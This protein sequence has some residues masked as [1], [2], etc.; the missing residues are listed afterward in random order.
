AQHGGGGP[1]P[2]PKLGERARA[3]DPLH[4]PAG[5]P[6]PRERGGV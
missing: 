4:H 6:P 2:A 3:P 5:G 1:P